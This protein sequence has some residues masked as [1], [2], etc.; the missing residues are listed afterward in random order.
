MY[1]ACALIDDMLT[2]LISK[3]VADEKKVKECFD[4]SELF[5]T[6][7]NKIIYVYLEGIISKKIYEDMNRIRKIRNLYAHNLEITKE[8]I[9][10]IETHVN[11]FNLLYDAFKGAKNLSIDKK[12][13]MEMGIIFVA[14]LKNIVRIKQID[15]KQYEIENLGWEN[16]DI[17]YI[18]KLQ[19]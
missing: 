4:S 17:E 2:E 18:K 12:I 13:K 14:L 9:Q 11:S 1:F 3:H 5:G 7:S 6:L 16:I 19:K 15:I 10:S 8:D